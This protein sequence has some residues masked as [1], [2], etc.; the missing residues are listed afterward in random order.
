[1]QA[2]NQLQGDGLAQ[3]VQGQSKQNQRQYGLPLVNEI[4]RF[5]SQ[6]GL[7]NGSAA[8]ILFCYNRYS[9]LLRNI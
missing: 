8:I 6:R 4:Q 5:N 9:S 7:A 3:S 2:S 1:M